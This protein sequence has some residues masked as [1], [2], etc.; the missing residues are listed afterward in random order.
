MIRN[1]FGRRRPRKNRA[2]VEAQAAGTLAALSLIT[3]KAH[4]RAAVTAR[5]ETAIIAGALN[6][7]K[8][9]PA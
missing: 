5:E 9:R 1:L 7:R 3:A 2:S 8:P 4:Q 6:G